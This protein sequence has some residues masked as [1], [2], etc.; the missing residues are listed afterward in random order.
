MSS[1]LDRISHWEDLAEKC[2]YSLH[3]MTKACGMSRQHLRRYFQQQL[4]LNPKEW[5]DD[6]RWRAASEQL[7]KGEPAKVVAANLQF[8]HPS[9]FSRFVKR[10]ARQTPQNFQV[11]CSRMATNVPEG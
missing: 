11:K 5:L 9:Q 4:Q 1:R 6:L 3:S 8:R 10:M 2:G 7:A